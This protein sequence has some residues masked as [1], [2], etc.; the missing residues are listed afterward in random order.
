MKINITPSLRSTLLV[1]CASVAIPLQAQAQIASDNASNAAYSGGWTN[2]SNGGTGFGGWGITNTSGSGSAGNFI[3]NPSAA[4]ITGMSATS[5]GF[6]ANPPNSGAN[7]AASRGFNT[8]LLDGETFSFQWGL[9]WDSDTVGSNRGFNLKSGGS[10]L[11]NINMSNS[12]VLTIN[13]ST[14]F[15]NYGAQAFTLNFQ[16][17]SSSSVRVYGTGRDGVEAYDNTFTGLSGR[18]DNFAFYFNATVANVDQRQMYFNDLSIVPEPSTW[19]LIG[20]GSAFLL[21]R[22]RRKGYAG[23]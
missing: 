20:I 14:M 9:N 17:I 10:E 4:G 13:G 1:A 7:A 19:V 2:G 12:A 8:A 11:L 16:Q 6:F 5:F 23:S 21:W 3:G 15:S 18:A 22:I